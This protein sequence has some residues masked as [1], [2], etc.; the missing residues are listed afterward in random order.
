MERA[1]QIVRDIR[2]RNLYKF[3]DEVLVP[4]EMQ[5][6]VTKVGVTVCQCVCV[7]AFGMCSVIGARRG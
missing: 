5:A 1:R 2:Q 7:C 6:H 3:A 4:K